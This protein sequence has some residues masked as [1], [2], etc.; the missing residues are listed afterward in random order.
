LSG[1]KLSSQELTGIKLESQHRHDASPSILFFSSIWAS[2]YLA[3]G[4]HLLVRGSSGVGETSI[5]CRW[6]T[7]A[8]NH[9]FKSACR[10]NATDQ[11]DLRRFP[12]HLESC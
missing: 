9:N 2:P 11:A 10:V 5:Q 8:V 6:W 3:S 12:L 7:V 1:S 4:N